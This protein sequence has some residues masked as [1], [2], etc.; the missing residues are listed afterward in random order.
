VDPQNADYRK[1]MEGYAGV[2][3]VLATLGSKVAA[4]VTRP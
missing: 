4:S 1:D 3:S 2:D